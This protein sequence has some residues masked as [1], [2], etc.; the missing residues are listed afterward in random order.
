MDY[1][2]FIEMLV[3]MVLVPVLPVVASFLVAL[4]NKYIAK[5]KADVEQKQLEKYISLAE[6]A[7]QSA[8]MSTTQTFVDSLK[9][10][11]NFDKEAHAEALKMTKENV[12]RIVADSTR[13]AIEM[14][15]GDFYEWMDLKIHETIHLDK[16]E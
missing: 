12:M 9:A 13:D 14:A 3:R 6:S 7:I 2:E 5:V 1:Q 10:A 8:V 16:K 11:G 4:L 15:Y